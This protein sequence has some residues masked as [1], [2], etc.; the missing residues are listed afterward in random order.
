[1][2]EI[3]YNNT[4]PEIKRGNSLFMRK[5]TFPRMIPMTLLFTITVILGINLITTGFSNEQP[6]IPGFAV[7]ALSFGMLVSLWLRPF[8]IM[9]R[10]ITVIEAMGDEKYIARFYDDRIE[11][12][13]EIV[14]ADTAAKTETVMISSS[15]VDVLKDP[16]AIA[17]A[18]KQ[19]IQPETSV[20]RLGAE[21]LYSVE[22]G[23]MFC[24]FI[25]KAWT[26]IFPKRCLTE[27]QIADLKKYFED[28]GI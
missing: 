8:M 11:I 28:K 1:M 9:K 14:T 26:V 27:G 24:L 20:Y 23:D 5:Y 19:L 3:N 21:T 12:D 25:N 4:I 17:E 13:T 15:G 7:T 18:E 22:A 16:E 10:T 2:L 6:S